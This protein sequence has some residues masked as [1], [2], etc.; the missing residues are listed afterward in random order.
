MSIAK[1]PDEILV[2]VFRSVD[3]S[4]FFSSAVCV[5][6]RWNHVAMS[7]FGAGVG[8]IPIEVNIGYQYEDPPWSV[9][10]RP[11]SVRVVHRYESFFPRWDHASRVWV[12]GL[13]TVLLDFTCAVDNTSI[14]HVVDQEKRSKLG[15]PGWRPFPIVTKASIRLCRDTIL[16]NALRSVM[17]LRPE[18]LSCN[19]AQLLVIKETALPGTFNFVRH[20]TVTPTLLLGH[21]SPGSS[22]VLYKSLSL[23]ENLDLFETAYFQSA[24]TYLPPPAPLHSIRA[25]SL[26]ELHITF[27]HLSDDAVC[28]ILLGL[29]SHCPNLQILG[30]FSPSSNFWIALSRHPILPVFTQPITIA[31]RIS[32]D[33]P[34]PRDSV[35]AP[36]AFSQTVT[37]LF[38]HLIVIEC[39][40]SLTNVDMG[41][42]KILQNNGSSSSSSSSQDGGQ[43]VKER[44]MIQSSGMSVLHQWVAACRELMEILPAN[45]LRFD[46]SSFYMRGAQAKWWR[47]DG[48]AIFAEDLK[49]AGKAMG[50]RVECLSRRVSKRR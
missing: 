21:D 12:A 27:I 20:L 50:K 30:D 25:C 17:A 9:E 11:P 45:T 44:L 39:R 2:H 5:S 3:S 18:A 26:R 49:R 48:N 32:K 7:T 35:E 14:Q 46:I 40:I 1:F 8:V 29:S 42:T 23:F 37:R 43:L 36:A 28:N 34:N 47:G 13:A 31:V 15:P 16:D 24:S 10:A 38:P 22:F 19:D 6:R 4:T 33:S 41:L